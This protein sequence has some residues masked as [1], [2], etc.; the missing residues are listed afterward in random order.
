M[1]TTESA[2]ARTPVSIP[3]SASRARA[4]RASSGSGPTAGVTRNRSGVTPHAA[5]TVSVT[6]GEPLV[7]RDIMLLF[8]SL[9]RP[10]SP[11]G[12]SVRAP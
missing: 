12:T 3:A 4:A 5:G 6:G 7:R 1:P 8:R 2:S 11:P 9:A 10:T